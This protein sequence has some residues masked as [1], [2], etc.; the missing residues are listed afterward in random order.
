MRA[1]PPG[2]PGAGPTDVAG[3]TQPR[4]QV[5]AVRWPGS[6][7]RTTASRGRAGPSPAAA[8]PRSDPARHGEGGGG[9]AA[10]RGGPFC[11]LWKG[12]A[13]GGA[14]F[15]GSAWRGR[16]S[17]RAWRAASLSPRAPP[18]RTAGAGDR[19][20]PAVGPRGGAGARDVLT[21]RQRQELDA[22]KA[23]AAAPAA[24]S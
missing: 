16:P 4:P 3:R 14:S 23:L 6:A 2:H 9:G 18:R 5:G 12:N 13:T 11:F 19:T 21:A 10:G 15:R 22:S 17:A 8:G 20:G 24:D 7:V 1:A